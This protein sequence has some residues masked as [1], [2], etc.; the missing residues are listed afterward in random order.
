MPDD[1]RAILDEWTRERAALDAV[2]PDLADRVMTRVGA[3]NAR[4]QVTVLA[5]LVA[6]AHTR[7]G[8]IV[9][10]TAAA[11]VYLFRIEQVLSLFIAH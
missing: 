8:Q 7:P 9:V 6:F 5:A 3:L 1:D 2:P 10:G 11:A 4:R